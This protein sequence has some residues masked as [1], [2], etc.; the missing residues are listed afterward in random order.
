MTLAW[1]LFTI[2]LLQTAW[3]GWRGQKKTTGFASFA[4]GNKDVHPVFVGITLAAS[5]ASAA[6]FIINPGFVLC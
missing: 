3:I 1:I 2:Y 5:V 6:T 4:L